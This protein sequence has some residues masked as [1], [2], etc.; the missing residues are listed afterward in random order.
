MNLSKIL[1]PVIKLAQNMGV[2]MDKNKILIVDDEPDA[3]FI[4]QKE[5]TARGYSVVTANNGKDAITLARSKHPDLIILDVAMPDMDGGQVA[6]K[7]QEGLSTKDIPIIFLTALFPK[8]KE[9]EQGHVVAGHVFI[10][11]PYD[12]EELVAQMKKLILGHPSEIQS[13]Y[14]SNS[15]STKAQ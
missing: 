2:K 7:L 3:L 5:L 1:L 10:A 15:N 13:S 4:L 6:E 11:K 8:R 12:I 9:E 14:S